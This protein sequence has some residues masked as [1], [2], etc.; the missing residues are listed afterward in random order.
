[1]T[2]F[3]HNAKSEKKILFYSAENNTSSPS[4]SQNLPIKKA[5]QYIENNFNEQIGL[6]DIADAVGLNA[7]Y[8][9]RLF[10]KETGE[11]IT[12]HLTQFRIEKAKELLKDE[13]LRL[14]DIAMAVGFNDVSYFSN[15]FK[16]IAGMSPTEFRMIS[17]IN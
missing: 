13:S 12:E 1:M 5:V 16:K 8:L 3:K 17:E 11:S 4:L 10:K 15:T 2:C 9:S 6:N 7:S 14:R